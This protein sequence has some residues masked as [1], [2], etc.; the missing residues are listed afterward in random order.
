MDSKAAVSCIKKTFLCIIGIF[1]VSVLSN[2][3]TTR[4][5]NLSLENTLSIFLLNNSKYEKDYYFCIP[6]QYIGDYQ[7]T[8]FEFDNGFILIGDY[9]IL[10]KRDNINIDVFVNESSDENGNT[11]GLHNIVY[12]ERNGKIFISKM[13]EPLTKNHEDDNMFNQYNIIIEN[14]LSNNEMTKIINEYKTKNTYSSFYIGYTITIDNE[15]TECG[16]ADDFELHNASVHEPQIPNSD[17]FPPNLE[18]FRTK[19]L[20]E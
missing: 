6:M 15:Q 18:F 11:D 4:N 13:N 7:I 10:L 8:S 3:I 16:Y 19:V 9:K 5:Y 17:W 12:S 2:C 20:Q 14:I 1:A